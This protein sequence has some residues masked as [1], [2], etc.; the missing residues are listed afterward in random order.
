MYDNAQ[1]LDDL[2]GKRY[3]TPLKRA[4]LL[5]VGDLI[6][7]IKNKGLRRNGDGQITFVDKDVDNAIR[8]YFPADGGIKNGLGPKGWDCILGALDYLGFEWR[9]HFDEID[10]EERNQEGLEFR[11]LKKLQ[12]VELA[13]LDFNQAVE[14]YKMLKAGNEIRTQPNPSNSKR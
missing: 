8:F 10:Y 6:E 9:G 3:A 11:I 14:N 1:T 4:D 5:T 2:I 12:V 13:I 7:A